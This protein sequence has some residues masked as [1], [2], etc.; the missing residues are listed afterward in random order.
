MLCWKLSSMK[1]MP[2]VGNTPR[3]E[4]VMFKFFQFYQETTEIQHEQHLR[5]LL[6]NVFRHCHCSNLVSL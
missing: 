5:A 1:Q 3:R 2:V 6:S 4:A